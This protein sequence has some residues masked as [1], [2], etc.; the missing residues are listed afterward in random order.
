MKTL[1]SL[2]V[3]NE[4]L[5]RLGIRHFLVESAGMRNCL[6]ADTAVGALKQQADHQPA[7]IILCAGEKPMDTVRLIRD[8]RRRARGQSVLVVSRVAGADHLQD[9]LSAG[10][11]GFV[12]AEDDLTEL[13]LACA[14]VL[15]KDLHISRLAAKHLQLGNGHK[16]A[17]QDKSTSPT[18]LLSVRE[19][20]VFQ[21]IGSGCG[22]KEV[23]NQLGIS[24]KTVQTHQK[25]MKEKLNLLH[26][27]DLK[28]LAAGG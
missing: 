16:K 4:P 2:I 21:L 13:Q 19:R 26:C 8:L 9:C 1:T 14:A 28:R 3:A 23:S 11:L 22:C 25:R 24:V 10:A 17:H 12:V 6:E 18:Q 15:K 20:E 7:L 5:L 27:S